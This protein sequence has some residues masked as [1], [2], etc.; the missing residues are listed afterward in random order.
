MYVVTWHSV[1][2]ILTTVTVG[3]RLSYVPSAVRH[4]RLH[5]SLSYL[6]V[7][8]SNIPHRRRGAARGAVTRGQQGGGAPPGGVRPRLFHISVTIFFSWRCLFKS[9]PYRVCPNI[10]HY[11]FFCYTFCV[12]FAHFKKILGNKKMTNKELF[13]L[14]AK[15][16]GYTH[17]YQILSNSEDGDAIYTRY[18]GK[19]IPY[20]V[21]TSFRK[22][23]M[24]I[25]ESYVGYYSVKYADLV[26]KNCGLTQ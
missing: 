12:N 4:T 18:K 24:V 14:Y 6:T 23:K 10:R 15:G 21:C 3:Q 11:S 19:L 7:E 16:K 22:H 2:I 13:R 20:I 8:E 9:N 26:P 25:F 1:D 5:S 17:S